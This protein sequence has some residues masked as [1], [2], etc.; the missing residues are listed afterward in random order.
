MCLCTKSKLSRRS[1]VSA[2]ST[3]AFSRSA[4]R[5]AN[6]VASRFLIPPGVVV[7]P[8]SGSSGDRK[9]I[10]VLARVMVPV[11]NPGRRN[12][13]PWRC[14]AES[15][16]LL[17]QGERAAQRGYALRERA[18]LVQR[19]S[20]QAIGGARIG[21]HA[22]DGARGLGGPAVVSHRRPRGG[23]LKELVDGNRLQ[24]EV[25]GRDGA[26]PNLDV[27]HEGPEP[28][29]ARRDAMGAGGQLQAVHRQTVFAGAADAE[30]HAGYARGRREA[31]RQG[32]HGELQ[33]LGTSARD[34]DHAGRVLVS[35]LAGD[36][37]VA[38]GLYVGQQQ[39]PAGARDPGIDAVEL[40]AARRRRP[41]RERAP[42]R[43]G[44]KPAFG[45][46]R[47]RRGR[48]AGRRRRG[49]RPPGGGC[50][51]A[52]AGGAELRQRGRFSRLE[53]ARGGFAAGRLPP[54]DGVPRART[55]QTVHRAGREAGLRQPGLNA[56]P[57]G[58]V[59]PPAPLPPATR[60]AREPRAP[61]RSAA[62]SSARRR[63][64]MR[65]RRR[66][67]A[68]SSA[69]RRRPMRTRHRPSPT[70]ADGLQ[71]WGASPRDECPEA[72]AG[73]HYHYQGGASDQSEGAGL[74]AGVPPTV[75]GL[76]RRARLKPPG[77]T[78]VCCGRP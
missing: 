53:V 71:E 50:R 4:L 76:A 59:E 67:A 68:P 33:D 32:C 49:C 13:P 29:P 57:G 41:D 11:Q 2:S 46:R 36:D 78:P 60:T 28:V 45:G 16:I 37:H 51:R 3:L 64:P 48:G 66:P 14:R 6:S 77:R 1:P 52:E 30:R 38:A 69:R 27:V 15:T 43:P 70:P 22:H 19:R 44:G 8:W 73:K 24:P 18:L 7:K 58:P 62:P 34:L 61:S 10:A 21:A 63:R 20:E 54:A 42:G 47:P 65:A 17:S 5:P 35:L 72:N 74:R 23:R 9:V 55:E 56:A 39:Y 31:A 40:D 75:T 12:M 26:R 25:E